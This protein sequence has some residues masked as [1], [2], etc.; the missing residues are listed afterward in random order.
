M[1]R[2]YLSQTDKKI[3][4]VC[5]GIAE[6]LEVDSTV[7]RLVTIVLGIVTGILPF[8][9]AYLIAWMIV[10]VKPRE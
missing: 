10:P 4:G 2:L 8:I 1:K 7:V 9:I 3:A 6:Y 5:G